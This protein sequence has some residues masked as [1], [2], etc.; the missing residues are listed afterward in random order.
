[1]KVQLKSLFGEAALVALMS[2][3]KYSVMPQI[4]DCSREGNV[5]TLYFRNK[6]RYQ[7]ANVVTELNMEKKHFQI[8]LS[9]VG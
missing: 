4:S 7:N 2:G 1:M 5:R 8:M 9:D 3:R 6:V